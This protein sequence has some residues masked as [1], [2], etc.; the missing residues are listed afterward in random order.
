MIPDILETQS[1]GIL[2]IDL[3]ALADNWRL[4]KARVAPAECT[5][6]V[7]ANAYGIGIEQAVPA[8]LRAGCKTFFT[9]HVSEAIR[10]RAV[11]SDATIYVLNGLPADS[12]ALYGQYNLRAVIGSPQDLVLW[13]N[14]MRQP[15]A[16]HVES[17]MNR[18]GFEPGTE[19]ILAANLPAPPALLMSHFIAAEEPDNAGNQRQ[20]DH[21]AH[22]RNYFDASV[23]ASL[24]NSSGI[25]LEQRPFHDLV[26]PGFALYGGNPTPGRANPMRPVVALDVRILQIRQ[27]AAG[28]TV[29]YN[30]RWTAPRP[31]RLAILSLGYADGFPMGAGHIDG[32]TTPGAQAIIAGYPCPFV[33]R[34][35]MDLTVVDVTDVP[36]EA[37]QHAAMARILG[38]E[39]SVNDLAERSGTI[40]YEI[41]TSLG[42]RF[43]RRYIA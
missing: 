41:L 11:A 33:G 15:F 16:L 27:I 2:T 22:V 12:V 10:A 28:Q 26:R 38:D 35:S 36:E 1:N 9:A 6:V 25:F 17:G 21:F 40:G 29:G 37:L 23:P 43:T 7:K 19:Q 14:H 24:C 32:R 34:T 42:R 8:L 18:L 20:I 31:S 5:A 3:R 39:I 30:A 4:L 13:Q